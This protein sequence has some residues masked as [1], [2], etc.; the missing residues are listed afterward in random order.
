MPYTN[1]TLTVK[2]QMKERGYKIK[3]SGIITE[4]AGKARNGLW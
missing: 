4:I 3:I 2:W 1:S